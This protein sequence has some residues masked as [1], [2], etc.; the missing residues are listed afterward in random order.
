MKDSESVLDPAYTFAIG[1]IHGCE[2]ALSRLLDAC[3]SWGGDCQR[4]FVFLGD[5]IDRGPESAAVIRRLMSWQEKCPDQ[6]VCLRGNHEDMLLLAHHDSN[7][8]MRWIRNGGLFTLRSFGV[9]TV[10]DIPK[11][12]VSWLHCLP[13]S[14]DDGRR[15]YVHAGVDLTLALDQQR[16]D[17]LLWMREPFLTLAESTDPGRLIVHGHTPTHTRRP[18][19]RRYR[20]N[21]D[22]GAFMGG[23]LTAAVFSSSQTG[24]ICFIADSGD[25]Q[26]L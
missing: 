23:P 3:N 4:R 5:Y 7:A 12:V 18:D 26:I 10:E 9:G 21:L 17:D 11:E 20:L 8:Y 6:V 2:A 19:L 1:D 22:T 25:V 13:S 14:F 15:F 24:P 16:I